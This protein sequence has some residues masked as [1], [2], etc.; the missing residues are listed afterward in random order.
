MSEA[1]NLY[2]RLAP[3]DQPSG[4]AH[5]VIDTPGGSANK[6]KYDEQLGTFKLTRMLPARMHF[7]Y[8]FGSV[9]GTRAEDGDPLDVLVL[10]DSPSFVGCLL[11]VVLIGGL[12]VEQ[13]EKRRKL[14]NDR[15]IAMTKTPVNAPEIGSLGQLG[16]SRVH[17]IEEFLQS[18]TRTRTADRVAL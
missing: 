1:D 13:F 10:L 9:P 16:R 2:R 15:L 17:A 7:P 11:T 6:Y 12:K 3:R 4:L 8:D 5:V 18:R 14:R